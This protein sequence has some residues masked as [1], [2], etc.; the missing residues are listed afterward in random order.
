MASSRSTSLGLI[1]RVL[2]AAGLVVDAVV[3]LRLAS[4]YQLAQPAGIGQGNLFRI[5]AVVAVLVAAY[6]LLRGSRLAFLTAAGVGLSA[7]AAVVLYRYV[8]VPGLGP[9]PPMYEPVWFFQKSLSAV[10]EGAAGALAL[11]AALRAGPAARS[12]R[13]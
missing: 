5:Q 9:I 8:Q 10:V 3:H 12:R 11:V 13:G 2:V 7:F 4:Q 1:V 6:V